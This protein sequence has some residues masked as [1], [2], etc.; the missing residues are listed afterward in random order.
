MG[1]RR[2]GRWAST[3]PPWAE[4]CRSDLSLLANALHGPASPLGIA[5]RFCLSVPEEGVP[6]MSD[7]TTAHR[8][9]PL[10]GTALLG[11]VISWNCP[12]HGHRR[13]GPARL[14]RS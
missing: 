2:L 13:A 6:R 1:A 10:L 8:F 3:T 9:S 14:R 5:G 4:S 11:E 12:R 7:P